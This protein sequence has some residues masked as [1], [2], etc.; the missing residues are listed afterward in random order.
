MTQQITI[1]GVGLI[2]GSFALALKAAGHT[3]K[4]VGYGRNE[5]NLIRAV[6]RGIIDS[7]STSL[8]KAVEGSDLVLVAA[9]VGANDA[10]FEQ[11]AGAVTKDCIVTDAGSVKQSV[12]AAARR[13]FDSLSNFVPAHPIAGTEHSGVEAGFASLY[14]G[15]RLIV[16]ADAETSAEASALV[17]DLWSQTGAVIET[18]TPA[19]HD[20]VFAATSHLPHL[21]AFSLVETLFRMEQQEEL[22]RYASGG[23]SDFTRIASSDPVM[24]KDICLHNSDCILDAVSHLEKGLSELTAAIERKDE[25]AIEHMFRVAKKTRDEK[26]LSKAGVQ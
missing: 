2:G 18:M 8:A 24:W 9:P 15:K 10:I 5:Q 13:H 20:K 1:I 3:A 12:I 4:F 14:Q 19:R 16:T 6:E 17:S 22:L 26:I 25:R 11:L 7:Y 21:L 23:F